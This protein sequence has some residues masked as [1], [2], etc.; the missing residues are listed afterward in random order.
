MSDVFNEF[1]RLRT[2][3]R[4]GRLN[5]RQ[6]LKRGAA[7]GLSAPLL[8]G[9][10]AACGGDEDEEPTT[11]PAEATTAPS[12]DAT[13]APEESATEEPKASPT[14]AEGE[15]TKEPVAEATEPPA[16][17]AGGGGQLRL[18]WWQAP[19][20]MNPHLSTGTK[21]FDAS[22]LVYEPLADFDADGN[23]I[24]ALAVE[25]PSLENGGVSED[26]L[27]VTWKL[28]DG[29]TWHDGEPFSADDVVFTWEYASNEAT[30]AVTIGNFATV[31]SVEA[32]DDVT[33]KITFTQQNPAWF[34]VFTGPN[35]MILP[36]HIFGDYIGEKSRDAEANLAPVGTGPFK[37]NEFRPGD[38]VLCDRYESYWDAGKPFFDS[39]EMK[40]GGDA[41]GAAR[42]VLQSGEA[43]W[44]WNIQAEPQILSQMAE[45]GVGKI[46]SGPGASAERIMINFADPN[47]EV[48]G[49]RSEP[50]T[51]H[52]IFRNK[53]A[54]NAIAVAIER[55]VIAKEL[56]GEGTSAE[57]G[58]ATSNNL[59]AP[60]RLVSPNTTWEYNL[61]KA[62]EL[63]ANVPEAAGYKLL[64]Q[65]SINSVRQKTQEIVKQSLEQ[66]GFVVELKS[67]DSAVFFASDAG[68]PDTYPHF[69]ADLEMYTNG[70]SSPYPV[71][72]CERFRTDEIASKANSWAGTNITRYN[73]PEFDKLHDQARVEMDPNKQ[74]DLFVAMNDLSVNDFVEVP[75]IHR[76]AVACAANTLAG[77]VGTTW[78]SDVYDI[79]NWTR[80]S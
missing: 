15:A 74:V 7:L 61:D 21:D 48:D 54:R 25:M 66:I 72:W 24:P 58:K 22:R 57:L 14:G 50:S 68:N 16:A 65:T 44:A 59:N 67:V 5:R 13:K 46:V 70:P 19:T 80:Q 12:G 45:G 77:Y 56:Y 9:L 40:G 41:Q 47:T 29:V 42:A 69:Y 38:V 78:A 60:G 64:Y 30:A 2:D 75:I 31:E 53:D 36:R 34:D 18:M 23:G 71:S 49:A 35:G 33:V 11:A 3:V 63:L 6:V 76:A 73:N 4:A 52:P 28:R 26:G 62:R 10:L 39:V 20:I 32:V 43:D 37:I 51:E 79:K 8:A 55:D 17:E 1:T 27:S